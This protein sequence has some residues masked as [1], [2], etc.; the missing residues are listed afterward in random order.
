MHDEKYMSFEQLPFV[1]SVGGK[2]LAWQPSRS[3][4]YQQECESGRLHFRQLQDLMCHTDNPL[5][6]SRV[7]QALGTSGQW[8]GAEAGFSQAM[9]EHVMQR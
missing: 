7:L 5:L 3:D 1:A 8:G 2:I 4:D 9:A 6:L